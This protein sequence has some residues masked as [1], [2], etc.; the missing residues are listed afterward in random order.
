MSENNHFS[1]SGKYKP[2]LFNYYALVIGAFLVWLIGGMIMGSYG[3]FFT[4]V[5]A[6]FGWTHAETSGA[7]SLM[8]ILSGILGVIAGR[9]SDRFSPRLVII[10]CSVIQGIAFIL[11]SRTNSLWQLYLFFGIMVGAGMANLAPLI[12]L[13]TKFY[14]KR[15]GVMTGITIAGAG[16]GGTIAPPLVLS[17][18]S[19]YGWQTT[20]LIMG[21]SFLV[22]VAISSFFLYCSRKAGP[23]DDGITPLIK[24]EK[25]KNR[26][27]SLQAAMRTWPFW[28][29]TIIV[30]CSGFF[31]QSLFVHLVPGAVDLR[32][33]TAGAAGLLSLVNLVWM[34]SSFS[35]GIVVDK[36]G[37]FRSF[38]IAL[39]LSLISFLLL[40]GIREL[41]AAYSF[42][43]FFGVG[44]GIL[45][46]ARTG[47]IADLFGLKSHGVINGIIMFFYTIGGTLGPILAGY[48]YDINQHYQLAFI[49]VAGF[50]LV[51]LVMTI[52]L[53]LQTKRTS[54]IY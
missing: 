35:M 27:I 53:K 7:F 22:L 51:S 11:L 25:P 44:W 54:R 45:V 40:F 47:L 46:L 32:L 15:R 36:M 5:S 24:R 21:V 20:Y 26:E 29:L 50:S 4:P 16:V 12:S 33:T 30:F 18:I 43:L 41:W 9:I 39:A 34:V 6:D 2:G 37:S 23:L 48:I 17:F 8:T 10:T 13:V 38:V 14:G 28:I 49:L 52:P 31:Q 1:S 3:V 19:S 42:T